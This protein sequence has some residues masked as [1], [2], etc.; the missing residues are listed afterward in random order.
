MGHFFY[1]IVMITHYGACLWHLLGRVEMSDFGYE[2]SWLTQYN[3]QY[4]DWS[5]KYIYSLYYSAITV[6]TVGYGD[7]VPATNPERVFT[8]IYSLFVSGILCYAQTETGYVCSRLYIRRE[9]DNKK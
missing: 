2:D 3:I 7:L 9:I 6:V 1:W 8:V 5:V 4:E